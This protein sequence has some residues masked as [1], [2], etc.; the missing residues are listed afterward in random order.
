MRAIIVCVDYGDILAVTLP[1]NRHH[2]EEVL[3]VTTPRD[4]RTSL[5]ALDNAA[6]IL[7]TDA[8]YER[9]ADFNKYLPLEMGLDLLGRDGWICL[10]D[11][12]IV[13]PREIP[14]EFV[15][16]NLYTPQ[17]RM[18]LDASVPPLPECRWGDLE[19][20]PRAE[21][22]GYS[23]IFHASDPH[24]PPPPW[25]QL[26]WKHA[27]GADTFFARLWPRTRRILTA[28]ECLHLG[29]PGEN[30]CGVGNKARLDQYMA[31]RRRSR[32]RYDHERING[33]AG[34]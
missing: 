21:F 6:G 26:D 27:G 22:C 5:V 2:F 8:F 32:G 18:Q 13:W 7:H 11:A 9:G 15:T 19:R 12:D 31:Q 20:W 14:G 23:Q 4:E 34:S 16:G 17:R 28:W 25:H 29:M 3:V 24:L 33:R 30:W 1:I 10:L